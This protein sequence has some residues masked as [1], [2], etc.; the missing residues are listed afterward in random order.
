MC[1]AVGYLG[2]AAFTRKIYRNIKYDYICL[3]TSGHLRLQPSCLTLSMADTCVACNAGVIELV[4]RLG[5]GMLADYQQDVWS[6]CW[7]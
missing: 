6:Q 4:W 3:H 5:A 2:A 7:P 1:G